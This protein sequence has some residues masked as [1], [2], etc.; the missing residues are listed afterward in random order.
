MG[1]I[2][3]DHYGQYFWICQCDAFGSSYPHRVVYTCGHM[4]TNERSECYECRE[5]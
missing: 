4:G 1:K 3:F 2:K 5:K